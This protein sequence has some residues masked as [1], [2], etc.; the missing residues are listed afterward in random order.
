RWFARPLR[1][2]K[3]MTSEMRSAGGPMR[4]TCARR[5]RAGATVGRRIPPLGLRTRPSGGAG[6]VPPGEA[7]V[8]DLGEVG[9][10]DA[11]DGAEVRGVPVAIGQVD[12]RGSRRDRG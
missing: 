6:E 11:A 2:A 5:R 4:S 1:V 7:E 3:R 9:E 10:V 12:K 8:E